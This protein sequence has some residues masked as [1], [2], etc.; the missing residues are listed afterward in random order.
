MIRL[1]C[2]TC[3]TVLNARPEHAGAVIG[4]PKC[5]TQMKVPAP[6]PAA[7]I[8]SPAPPPPPIRMPGSPPPVTEQAE[9]YYTH[10]GQQFGPLSWSQF[11]QLAA[12]GQLRRTDMVWKNGM[13]GWA[14][15]SIVADLFLDNPSSGTSLIPGMHNQRFA[16]VVAAGVGMLATFLPWFYVP[17]IGSV[18]GTTGAAGWI[19][20]VLFIPAM[21]RALHSGRFATSWPFATRATDKLHPVLGVDRL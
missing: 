14:P 12:S 6:V 17:I 15:A 3:K 1:S 5:K 7:A 20:L 16:I 9:W 21:V 4:C 10:D 11:R 2:P 18:S 8:Q 13:Q 19:T